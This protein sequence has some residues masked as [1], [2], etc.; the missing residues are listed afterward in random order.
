MQFNMNI[1]EKAAVSLYKKMNLNTTFEP[2]QIA[3]NIQVDLDNR[4]AALLDAGLP[5]DSLQSRSEDSAIFNLMQIHNRVVDPISFVELGQEVRKQLNLEEKNGQNAITNA[6]QYKVQFEL[7][8]CSL[9]KH[10]S[11]LKDLNEVQVR[12]THAKITWATNLLERRAMLYMQR[13][14]GAADAVVDAD[15]VTF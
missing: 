4:R 13:Y 7:I 9:R 2:A 12:D 11:K 6:A 3:E 10:I 14:P 1:A 8:N 5:I 15:A